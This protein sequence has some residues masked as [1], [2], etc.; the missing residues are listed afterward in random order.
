MSRVYSRVAA[1]CL[2]TAI[3]AV[4]IACGDTQQSNPLSPSSRPSFTTVPGGPT[5]VFKLCKTSEKAGSFT[6][7]LTATGGGPGVDPFPAT[8]NI[9][10]DADMTASCKNVFIPAN[11]AAWTSS[12]K[13]TATE[14]VPAGM[15]ACNVAVYNGSTVLG[16]YPGS[17]TASVNLA[18]GQ[19]VSIEWRN[20]ATTPPVVISGGGCTPGYWKQSQ[21]FDSWPTT[22]HTGDKLSLY[23]A[24]GA[25]MVDGKALG[26]YTMLDG[27][28]MKGGSGIAGANQ[29]LMRAAVAAY[30]NSAVN[31]LHYPFSTANVVSMVNTALGSGNR[32]LMI[33][34]AAKLDKANN[35]DCTLN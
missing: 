32:D 30:L 15:T 10:L 25:Q 26:N 11:P 22:V 28:K 4:V 18:Y 35:G 20:C 8:I 5:G 16:D 24:T 13:I 23:F 17:T 7:Q 14:L 27:L 29:I 9:T 2:V 3:A 34:T 1:A 12:M 19:D 33:L 31:A 21:H 6:F